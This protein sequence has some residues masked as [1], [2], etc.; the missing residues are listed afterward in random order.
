MLLIIILI[1]FIIGTKF[2]Y[3][4]FMR[5]C[6]FPVIP[7][8][9]MQFVILALTVV[10][11]LK[12]FIEKKDFN[13]SYNILR[14]QKYLII[15]F[16]VIAIVSSLVNN[17]NFFLMI[18]TFLE[19]SLIN[20]ILFIAILE[21]DLSEKS[22]EKII[23][24]IYILIFIQI[25]VAIF[26]Y[27][28]LKYQSADYNS[29][30]ISS[31]NKNDGTGII[32]ILMAFLLSFIISHILAKGFTIKKLILS[33]LTFIPCIVGGSRFGLI[34]LPF[35]ILLTVLSYFVIGKTIDIKKFFRALILTSI[36]L[37]IAIT[38]SYLRCPC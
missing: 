9:A 20:L 7:P 28:F 12:A 25:P 18:K 19:F 32:A 27:V 23:K 2:L 24:I 13:S 1:Y 4:F 26:Q 37:F 34:L 14:F 38:N 35:A 3:P 22:Q 15:L 21:T 11:F 10:I 5:Y 36:L 33:V 16:L 31:T 30:T 6:G 29:G 17:N 8:L